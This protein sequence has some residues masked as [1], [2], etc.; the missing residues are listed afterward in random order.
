MPLT[1]DCA[2]QRMRRRTFRER[3]GGQP[4]AAE[5]SSCFVVTMLSSTV[6][7][8]MLMENHGTK[9][10]SMCSKALPAGSQD[11]Q[12]SG[13]LQFQKIRTKPGTA[14]A[15]AGM[16]GFDSGIMWRPCVILQNC[17]RCGRVLCYGTAAF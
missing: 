5:A 12:G 7:H 2:H 8:C 11:E 10:A 13:T 1:L 3:N 9:P 17:L 14:N 16:Q 15:T 4:E 6:N